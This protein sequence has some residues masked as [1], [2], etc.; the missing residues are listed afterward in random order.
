VRELLEYLLHGTFPTAK[1]FSTTCFKNMHAAAEEGL[2][3]LQSP[4]L[5]C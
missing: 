5:V 1:D 2:E 4:L 3:T